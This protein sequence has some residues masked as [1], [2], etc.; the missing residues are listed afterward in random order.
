MVKEK[1][2]AVAED[3]ELPLGSRIRLRRHAAGKSLT[4]MAGAIGYDKGWL[5]AVENNRVNASAA[6]IDKISAYLDLSPSSLKTPRCPVW[7]PR[8]RSPLGS[9]K[10]PPPRRTPRPIRRRELGER[11]ERLVGNA[12]LTRQEE[13]L[14]GDQIIRV[15]REMIRLVKATRDLS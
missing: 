14:V 13:Q 10:Q 8:W 15:A 4:D 1:M 9:H 2:P 11:I 12:R 7:S 3:N 5:S 6:L